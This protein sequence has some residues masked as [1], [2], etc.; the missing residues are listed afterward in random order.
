MARALRGRDLDMGDSIENEWLCAQI[1]RE[2][3]I[4]IARTEIATFGERK[5]GTHGPRRC[6]PRGTYPR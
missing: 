2:L 6:R 4:D 5:A 1:I 3:G